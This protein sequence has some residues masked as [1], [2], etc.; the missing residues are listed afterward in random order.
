MDE[1]FD[2][3]AAARQW[4]ERVTGEVA[5]MSLEEKVAFFQRFSS[6]NV[7]K[8]EPT[9]NEKLPV[10]PARQRGKSFDAVAESRKWRDVASRRKL[11]EPIRKARKGVTKSR[12]ASS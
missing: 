6:V 3:V 5:A 7:L 11:L 2:A 12:A 10:P 9:P 8:A 1:T 4:R